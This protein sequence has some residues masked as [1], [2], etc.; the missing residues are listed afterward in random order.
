MLTLSF[1]CIFFIFVCCS[2]KDEGGEA[3]DVI[4]DGVSYPTEP[5]FRDGVIS[6][7]VEKAVEAGTLYFASAGDY[8]NGYMFTSVSFPAEN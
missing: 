5:A 4:V 2:G 1:I 3:C 8:G 6:Q 7:A